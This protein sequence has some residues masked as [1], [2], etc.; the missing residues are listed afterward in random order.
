MWESLVQLAF[1]VFNDSKSAIFNEGRLELLAWHRER[2]GQVQSTYSTT[3]LF[4]NEATRHPSSVYSSVF[5]CDLKKICR[6]L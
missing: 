2:E 1:E 3:S 6:W 4:F 5:H